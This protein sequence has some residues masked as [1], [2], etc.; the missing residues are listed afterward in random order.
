MPIAL[1]EMCSSKGQVLKQDLLICL[2]EDE[3]FCATEPPLQELG[4]QRLSEGSG[5]VT[6]VHKHFVYVPCHSPGN[7]F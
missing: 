3:P 7:T 4:L 5:T 1:S 6:E 2:E